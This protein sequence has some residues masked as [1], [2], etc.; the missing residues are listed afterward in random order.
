MLSTVDDAA[1]RAY[2]ETLGA[3]M[4]TSVAAT[5]LLGALLP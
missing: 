3:T 2:G 4:L 1:D 5:L